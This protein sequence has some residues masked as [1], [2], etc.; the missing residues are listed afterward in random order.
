MIG[1]SLAVAYL[2]VLLGTAADIGFARDEGFYF[3][4]ADRYQQWFDILFKKPAEAMKKEVV[5]SHWDMNAE[6]PPLAKVA[7]GLSNRLFN[8]KLGW[9]QPSTSYRLPGMI[10]G[11]VLLYLLFLFTAKRFGELEAFLA[12]AFLALMPGF[13]YHS[14]LDAFDVPVTLAIFATLY[15]FEKSRASN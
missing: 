6:H 8:H 15:A 4:A 12:S 7:F 5:E 11:A 14:H 2:A 1:G 10:C 9:L 3:T 13:F